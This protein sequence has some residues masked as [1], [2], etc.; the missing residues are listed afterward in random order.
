MHLSRRCRTPT[1]RLTR[2]AVRRERAPRIRCILRDGRKCLETLQWL[3][4]RSR[5]Q[6]NRHGRARLHVAV[7]R[8]HTQGLPPRPLGRHARRSFVVDFVK[9]P[10]ASEQ[11]RHEQWPGIPGAMGVQLESADDRRRRSSSACHAFRPQRCPRRN[12]GPN[13]AMDACGRAWLVTQ[14]AGALAIARLWQP[15]LDPSACAVRT[16]II[17]AG[18]GK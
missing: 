1:G 16:N 4:E 12:G 3:R 2:R 15:L 11:S 17:A 9:Q 13:L 8:Q 5:R 7:P 6:P 14:S 18:Y 10:P